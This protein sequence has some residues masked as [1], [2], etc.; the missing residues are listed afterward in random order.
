MHL[1]SKT[2]NMSRRPA[3]QSRTER[4]RQLRARQT[5]AESLIWTVVRARRLAGLKFRRQHPI[6]P[7]YADFACVQMRVIVELDGGYHD[8]QYE[9]DLDRQKYLEA[10]GWQVIRFRNEDVLEDVEAVAISIARQIGVDLLY[11]SRSLMR[12]GPSP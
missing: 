4:S 5:K 3:N 9:G 6:G 12:R 10:D 8:F 2:N 11:R 1:M 7:F